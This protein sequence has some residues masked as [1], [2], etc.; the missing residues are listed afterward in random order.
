MLKRTTRVI[1]PLIWLLKESR[2][3]IES[4]TQCRAEFA[5]GRDH[6]DPGS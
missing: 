6:H 1:V 2:S 4:C 5:D 3:Y